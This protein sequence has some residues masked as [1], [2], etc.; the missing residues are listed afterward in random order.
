MKIKLPD[1]PESEQTPLVKSLLGIIEQLC[2]T[3]ER[4]REEIET[5]KDEVRV[6]KG[7]KKRPKFK[8]SKLD[9][10]TDNEKPENETG[11]SNNKRPGSAKKSKNKYLVIHQDKVI[12][13]DCELP[14][15]M[16]FKGYRDYIV[17]ELEIK[18]HN[19]R[20]RLAYY[21]LPNGSTVTATLP[22]GL[23]GQHFGIQLRSYIL[24]QY[25]QCQVTQPL[26][27]EQLREWGVDISSGQLNR[28][29]T[30]KHTDFHI[31]KDDLLEKG[32]KSRGYI[33]TDDTGARHKGKNG[34]VTHIG[35]EWFAWFQSSDSKSRI[36]FLSL[37][38]AGRS[39]Y[40]INDA[41]LN[42]MKT[43]KL[44]ATQLTLLSNSVCIQFNSQAQWQTHLELLG[45]NQKRHQ[46]IATEGVLLGCVLEDSELE[47][48]AIVSDGAGQFNVLQH[49]LCWVHAERLIHKLVPLN[50]AHR[51]DI[52]RVRDDIWSFYRGLKAYK[53]H[54]DEESKQA[55]SKEFERIFSQKTRY[56]L[57]NQQLKRLSKL[58]ASLLLVLERPEIPIHTNGSENDLREQV[59]RRKVSGGTRSDL[60]RQCRDTFS[61]L[62]KT[63]RKLGISFWSYL[64]DR[65]AQVKVIPL[66]GELVFQKVQVTTAF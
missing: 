66:L 34:F 33:T 39:D 54:P 15:G 62:K 13:P 11:T 3:V 35:N 56:E 5:L 42:Y 26:L 46:K 58:K 27:L 28:L 61:S 14:E 4:Q 49:G 30:E 37:L 9:K 23:A 29:L 59:K 36:N 10:S 47:K 65:L 45:I 63:C 21:Q 31:E 53:K 7:Q 19:I 64:N 16:S 48:L 1:I 25:H 60:G 22:D 17:Q 51:E 18:P 57:L 50:D 43:H 38:R 8:A 41:A 6:L 32:L 40:H 24:Y 52:K 44:P 55:L 12:Q 2:E 20:Y